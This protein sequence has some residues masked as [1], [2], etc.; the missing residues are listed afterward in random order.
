MRQCAAISMLLLTGALSGCTIPLS[1]WSSR[2][3]DSPDDGTA[4][5]GRLTRCAVLGA[6]A[7]NDPDC[8]SAWAEARRRILPV[9][10]EK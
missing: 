5:D 10:P 9:H 6:N 3:A 1:S 4:L 2:P 8:Q 7:A